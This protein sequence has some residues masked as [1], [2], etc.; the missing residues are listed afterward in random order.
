M[1]TQVLVLMKKEADND[2]PPPLAPRP[3][4]ANPPLLLSACRRRYL[5]GEMILKPKFRSVSVT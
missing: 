2:V 3:C 5:M 1:Q 4:K